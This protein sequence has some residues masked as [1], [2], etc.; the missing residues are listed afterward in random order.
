MWTKT[1]T[2]PGIASSEITPEDTYMNRRRFMTLASGLTIAMSSASGWAQT[3]KGP[4]DTDEKQTPYKDVTTYNNFYEF[5]IDKDD[6]TV[7]KSGFVD[8][9]SMKGNVGDQ[10]YDVPGTAD[11]SK[12]QAV[13]IW[14]ARFNVN[15]GTAPMTA[16]N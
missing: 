15:F 14:C 7:K 13:T 9:G 16:T 4:Y 5:G 1:Q 10:N 12:Y 2:I 11:L 3:K 6:A 8:L